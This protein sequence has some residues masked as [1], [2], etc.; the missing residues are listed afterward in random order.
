MKKLLKYTGVL[1]GILLVIGVCLAYMAT[2]IS[3]RKMQRVVALRVAPVDFTDDPAAIARGKYLFAT[4]GCKECHGANGAGKVVVDDSSGL[5]VRS[6]NITPGPGSAVARYREV[7]WVRAVRHGVAPSGR[8][9]LI[10]PC[11]DYAPL[12]DV[13]L[14]ALVAYVRHL[15][16]AR[17]QS[18]ELRLS[19]LVKAL[20]SVGAIQDAA[21]KIDHGRP[22]SEPVAE[23]VSKEHG[24]YVANACIGCHGPGL[25]GGPIP[26]GPPDWPPAANLTPGEGSVMLRYDTPDKFKAMIR[27]GKRPDGSAVSAVMPFASLK[28]MNDIDLDALHVYLGSL[29]PRAFGGR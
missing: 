24:A 20:Y 6:P 19:L 9:L 15:E 13:D 8:P 23:A 4:R 21:E 25:S 3:E 14:K 29:A 28:E 1:V 27:S 12:T 2:I 22:P 18:A 7:D 5:Y 11:E 17:G 10:M 16:P 26:G